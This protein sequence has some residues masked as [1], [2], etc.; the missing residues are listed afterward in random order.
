MPASNQTLL[1]DGYLRSPKPVHCRRTLDQF[2]YYM[3]S[4]TETRDKSQVAYKWAKDTKACDKAKD[5]PI[6]MVDQLWVWILHNGTSANTLHG[7]AY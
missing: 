4:S 5:R 7:I 1:L 6:I 3:L 2:S